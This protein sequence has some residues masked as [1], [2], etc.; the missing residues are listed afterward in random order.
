MEYL[1]I[2]QAIFSFVIALY[3]I[4]FSITYAEKIQSKAVTRTIWLSTDF[5]IGFMTGFLLTVVTQ[6][7]VFTLV[8]YS[9]L[10]SARLV[11]IR[12]ILFVIAGIAI[13][14]ATIGW[15]IVFKVQAFGPVFIALCLIYL[16]IQ[17]YY[18]KKELHP[19]MMALLWFLIS[20]TALHFFRIGWKINRELFDLPNIYTSYTS[21][22]PYL[23]GAFLSLIN[24]NSSAS[25]GIT[26]GLAAKKVIPLDYA[27]KAS[28]AIILT[29]SVYI[30]LLFVIIRKRGIIVL[31]S[32]H[33]LALIMLL[34]SFTSHDGVLALLSGQENTTQAIA[35]YFTYLSLDGSEIFKWV[36]VVLT[37]VHYGRL[38]YQLLKKRFSNG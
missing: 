26:L 25:L 3:A 24:Q 5:G 11:H 21:D 12:Q 4:K 6:S 16:A 9:I 33:I 18:R 20:V 14:Q 23:G 8:L 37:V 27:L 13:A 2:A 34:T 35:H 15:V 36:A 7:S 19:T 32:Y 10:F 29:C 22:S 38:G 28:S 30:T 17:K 1:K 31:L